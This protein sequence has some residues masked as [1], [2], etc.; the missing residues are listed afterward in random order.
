MDR[1]LLEPSTFEASLGNSPQ[2]SMALSSSSSSCAEQ[3]QD[4]IGLD[5]AGHVS[6]PNMD[7]GNMDFENSFDTVRGGGISTSNSLYEDT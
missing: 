3:D 4:W 1:L 7:G 6:I 2:Y 5:Y